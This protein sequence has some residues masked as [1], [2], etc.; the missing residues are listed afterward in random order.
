MS[1]YPNLPGV[2]MTLKDGQMRVTSSANGPKILIIAP[3]KASAS[4]LVPEE[5]VLISNESELVS[6]FGGY[7]TANILNPIAAEWRIARQIGGVSVYLLALT[8]ETKKEQFINLYHKL[9]GDLQEFDAQHVI[10][11]GL[12][13]DD[14]ITGVTKTDFQ[15]QEDKDAFPSV[16]GILSNY[17]AT[18]AAVPVVGSFPL[19]VT[20]L[21][22]TI[23]LTVSGEEVALTVPATTYATP[24]ALIAAV[25]LSLTTAPI[26]G[27]KS[28]ILNG[29]G[30][31]VLTL[32]EA[33]TIG[34]GSIMTALALGGV[35]P[36]V[37]AKG[38]PAA[39]LS[40]YAE[41]QNAN[42]GDTVAY[43]GVGAPAGTQL[44]DIKAQVNTL[45][46]LDNQYSQYLQVI[47][48]PSV[49]VTVPG[50]LRMQWTN[51][52]TNYACL[53]AGL[54]PQV[55][56]TNQTL[57]GTTAL[58]YNLSLRQLNDLTGKKYVTFRAKNGRISVV[59][60]VTTAPDIL[61][62]EDLVKSDYTRLST[63]R[64]VNHVVKATR[65]ALDAFIGAPNEFQMYTAMNTA[66]K[67][68]IKEAIDRAIIQ[69]ARYTIKLGPSLDT[70]VVE[71]TVLPQ[72]E[73]RTV[74]VSIG[75]ST[76][77]TY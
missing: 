39:L 43:I 47:A 44:S 9:F 58:R 16:K 23:T 14:F 11:V 68:V 26:F 46:E 5:P 49:G 17:I 31:A 54:P 8:G 63:L 75:L 3:V 27:T 21:T 33:F 42:V 4:V 55:A 52:A 67:G 69:D 34:V 41:E 48:G 29:T 7:F 36:V 56:P 66:I 15:F 76:P 73:L 64:I 38:N 37:E 59:D 32:S 53:T 45:L 35:T 77:E 1:N 12:N 24:A 50:S 71:M 6:K 30:K 65:E 2:N 70:S 28:L 61:I 40:A 22:Q 57:L 19:T 74:Q 72:F 13:A 10:L 20:A 60:G 25:Q 18:A 62:G 51:G